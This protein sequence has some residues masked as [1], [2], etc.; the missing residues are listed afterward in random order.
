MMWR[1]KLSV[2]LTGGRMLSLI[3]SKDYSLEKFSLNYT[4][5]HALIRV[6]KKD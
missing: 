1:P 5:Q 4:L 6:I 3:I 2:P